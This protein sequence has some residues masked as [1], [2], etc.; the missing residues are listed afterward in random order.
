MR[1]SSS[2]AV[3]MAER[4]HHI[5]LNKRRG[6]ISIV[7]LLVALLVVS[8]NP[9]KRIGKGE[10]LLTHNNFIYRPLEAAKEPKNKLINNKITEIPG[11]EIAK[12]ELP[13]ELSIS[14]LDA[15]IKQKPNTKILGL[16]PLHL[17]VYNLV[18]PE[19]TKERR[20]LKNQRIDAKNKKIEEENQIRI[21]KGKKPKAYKSKDPKV[22]SGEWLMGV[23]EPPVILDSTLMTGSVNQVT[24]YLHTKGYFDGKVTDSVHV[25]DNKADVY[26][27]VQSGKP[28][29]INSLRYQLDDT[30]LTGIVYKDSANS[31]INKGDNFDEDVLKS[32]RDRLTRVLRNDGYYAFSKEY[33]DFDI[34]TNK[35]TKQVSIVIDI[36]KFAYVDP[37]KTDSVIETLHRQ[38]FI[39]KVIIQMNYSP[40]AVYNTQDTVID[41]EYIIVSPAG[42]MSFLPK[43]LL[44]KIHIKPGD[45]F[46]IINVDNTYAGLMQMKQFRYINIRWVETPD[47]NRLDCY[48]QLMPN[49][50]QSFSAEVIGDNTGGFWGAQADGTYQ[51]NNLFKG[52]EVLQFKLKYALQTQ[53]LL[54]SEEPA[55]LVSKSLIFNTQDIGP[56]ASVIVPRPLF[57]FKF[58][59]INPAVA[60]PQT[61]FKVLYD[62]QVQPDYKRNILTL[63]YGYDFN[64]A[65]HDHLNITLFEM[66]FVSAITSQEFQDALVQ[67]HD[68]FLENSFRT[69]AITDSRITWIFNNQNLTKLRNY[70]YLKISLEGSGITIHQVD[71]LLK[72]PDTIPF[73]NVPLSHYVKS[74]IDYRHFIIL[75]KDDKLAFRAILGVGVPILANTGEELP[76]DKSFWTGGSNDI[77]GW[78][79]RTLGPGANSDLVS[80]EEVGDIKMEVNAEYRVNLIKFFGLAFF[81]DGGNV[82]LWNKNP[83]IPNGEF[84][85][86]GRYGFLNELAIGTGVGFRFDFNYF[87]FRV[88]PGLP[89]IDPSSINEW[90]IPNSF[91]ENFTLRKT[92]LNIGIGYPF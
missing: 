17:F 78:E 6:T 76:F 73:T 92:V 57:P 40:N 35:T 9:A 63:N 84:E 51:N 47:S 50:K 24:K 36:K 70:N 62:F 55:G 89:L 44:S 56:E 14:Q 77:R 38:Y 54:S 41:K 85:W 4:V 13:P 20:V 39:H 23:G 88:D 90:D 18:D 42:G 10:Y 64:F 34:D 71:N 60:N 8:C 74:D 65:K 26:Y 25:E 53:T 3:I 83:S 46:Q 30:T 37:T 16:I 61:A 52:A 82:W 22:F 91:R 29:K 2:F 12:L 28:Y 11:S 19:K 67:T 81:L 75:S 27:I 87:V 80:V 31:L 72:R 59:P 45:M 58:I 21:E 43:I 33:I 1:K 48:I 15:Y 66:N 79:A 86:E 5:M 49:T 69:Q 7:A 32:E 68:F